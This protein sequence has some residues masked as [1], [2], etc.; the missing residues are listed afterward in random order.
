MRQLVDKI[1]TEGFKAQ[2]W[3]TPLAV[4]PGTELIQHHPDQLLLN[5][6]GSPQKITWWNS[7]YLCPAYPKVRQDARNFVIKAMS[8]WGFDGLKIDG[9]HLNGAPP[10]YNPAHHHVV[11]EDSVEGVPGFF[12]TIYDTALSI[13]PQALV[14]IC[15][16]GTSYSFFSM[17]YMNM[18]VASDP[19]SS[20]QIRLKGKVLKALMGNSTAYF[21]DHVDMSD[22]GDDFASTVGVGGVIGT[23]F[24]WPVGS[25]RRRKLDLTDSKEKIW[26]QWVQI[27][28]AK[29]LSKGNY[30]GTLYDIGFDKPET[31]VITKDGT[32]YYAFYAAHWSGEVELRGLGK[33]TY[34]VFDYVGGRDLGTVTGPEAT[35]PVEFDKHLLLEV[36]PEV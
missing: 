5:A 24:S 32:M 35:L 2:L 25:G 28:K 18:S 16:C 30:L 17:P 1:H 6:D 36:K 12:K 34:H 19:G 13:K 8:D 27:Y 9:Q 33:H 15:P 14:E 29:M 10:C 4:D 21:G 23:N 3:W 31:H 22:G 26:N 20:W 11:P 7:F